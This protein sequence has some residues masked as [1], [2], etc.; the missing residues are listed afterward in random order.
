[1]I[2]LLVAITATFMALS[3][4]KSG[5]LGQAMSEE[6]SQTVDAWSYY[7]AKSM[8]QNLAES[9]L[10]QLLVYRAAAGTTLSPEATAELDKK[11]AAYTSNVARY[12][13]EKDDIKTEAEGHAKEYRR[14]NTHDDQF[15][16]SDAALSVSIALMGVTALTKKKWLLVFAIA[17]MLFGLF[18][19]CAGFFQWT[20][21]PEALTGIF[22]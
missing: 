14:L 6:Q 4:V 3:G 8:K 12:K 22:S 20:V 11:I 18:F 7:Q 2:A 13:K 15:D 17:F 16:L 1:M 21:H 19:G 5:N 9:T 10:D